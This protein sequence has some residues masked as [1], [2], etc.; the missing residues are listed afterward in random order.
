[1]SQIQKWSELY[2]TKNGSKKFISG[3]KEANDWL[4]GSKKYLIDTEDYYLSDENE[5][6]FSSSDLF[7]LPD[8]KKEKNQLKQKT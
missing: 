1:M 3:L 6:S 4:N 7:N 8:N 2:K 5:A